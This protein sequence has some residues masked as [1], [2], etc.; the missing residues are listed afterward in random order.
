[1]IGVMRVC[2]VVAA[3]ALCAACTS[4]QVGQETVNSVNPLNTAT[5]EF[6]VGTSY[7]DPAFVNPTA[8]EGDPF[9]NVP[10]PSFNF[11]G[12]F[13]GPS[14]HSAVLTD[15][16]SILGPQSFTVNAPPPKY[17]GGL[18]NQLL[19][20]I[21]SDTLLGDGL[22]AGLNAN[23]EANSNG[24][25]AGGPPAWPI[26]TGGLYPQNFTGYPESLGSQPAVGGCP[27]TPAAGTW[28]LQVSVPIGENAGINY[29]TVTAT[30]NMTTLTHLPV[31]P[32]PVFAPDGNG[33]GTVTLDVPAGVT[34]AFVNFV[35][36]NQICY[37]PPA[38]QG[39]LSNG[40]TTSW[41]YTLMTRKTGPQTLVL[42]DNLGPPD[43]KTG[44][45]LHTFCTT[46]DNQ[47]PLNPG[48]D[49][50]PYSGASVTYA[51]I[52][53]DYPAFEQSYPQSTVPN[54]QLAGTNGQ[55]DNTQSGA[56]RLL[57]YP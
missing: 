29:Q 49:T 54:P 37:P 36:T 43:P 55:A 5:L 8:C 3:L 4:Q 21:S 39:T 34:E 20:S 13:R 46:A 44:N 31:F 41:Y 30:A 42:P 47:T 9:T 51:A 52:G 14:G 57:S 45:P 19:K 38:V 33:G 27:V 10:N 23:Y 2:A 17:D 35:A 48:S 28:T 16:I 22:G 11:V 6:V 32:P 53:V 12:T 1:M 56:G 24:G 26:V 40:A 50:V 7:A 15:S 18:P 25:F